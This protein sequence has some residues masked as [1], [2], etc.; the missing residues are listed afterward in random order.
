MGFKRGPNVVTDGLVMYL[1]VGNVKSFRGEPT[2]NKISGDFDTTFDSFSDGDNAGFLNQLG[3]GNYLGVSSFISYKGLKSLRINRG[4]GGTGRVYRTFSVSTGEFSSISAWV[5]SDVAGP[6]I[7]LEYFGGDYNWG[8]AYNNNIHTGS[9]WELIWCRTVGGA[10]SPTTGYYFLHPSVNNFDTYWDN[11]QVENKQ[12][13]TSYVNGTRGTTVLSGGGVKDLSGF[14]NNGELFNGPIYG[15]LNNGSLT[16]DGVNDYIQT[17][18]DG[19]YSQI[20]F[21]FWGFFEDPTLNTTSRNESAFGD[22]NDNRC[23]FGTRWGVGMHWNVN[24]LWVN[25]PNTNLKYGWN[26]YVLV[27]NTD[28]NQ[29]LVYLNGVLSSTETTNG[30][31]VLRDFKIGV[32]TNLNAF[33]SGKISIFKQYVKALSNVEILQNYNAT[34]ERYIV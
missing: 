1:D 8:V 13:N 33:Y 18:I 31:M 22:W 25:I 28:T 6:F 30:R 24:G 23:H 21:E 7:A 32:A 34:K 14:N 15:S 19:S 5:Y 4:S 29:K 20:T 3:S 10:T 11:I 2:F 17:S 16:F 26:H 27:Y 12:Y 9:G